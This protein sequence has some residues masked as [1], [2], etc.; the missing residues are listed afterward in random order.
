MAHCTE[1][2]LLLSFLFL[3]LYLPPQLT[4]EN[5]NHKDRKKKARTKTKVKSTTIPTD[6]IKGG[7]KA[8]KKTHTERTIS[9]ETEQHKDRM[10]KI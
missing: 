5:L 1:H 7:V 8:A 4:H 2:A 9:E 6:V 3:F 10:T